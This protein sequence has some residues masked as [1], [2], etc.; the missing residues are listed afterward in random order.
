M[1]VFLSRTLTTPIVQQKEWAGV[2]EKARAAEK[3]LTSLLNHRVEKPV[4]SGP[5]TFKEWRNGAYLFVEKNKFFFGTDK[6]IQGRVLGPF[7]N[8]IR[9]GL[10]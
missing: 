9:A 2:A 1:A 8:G 4:G 6:N 5:F 3:P 7:I 10:P